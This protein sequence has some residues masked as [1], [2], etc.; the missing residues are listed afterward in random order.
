MSDVPFDTPIDRPAG[1]T[2]QLEST[3]SATP[4]GSCRSQETRDVALDVGPTS[5][6]LAGSEVHADRD[7]RTGGVVD[8]DAV[9]AVSTVDLQHVGRVGATDLG[10]GV[11][12]LGLDP[13][14]A[15]G[16][17]VNV[18][19]GVSAVEHDCVET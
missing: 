5:E 9:I 19:R 16:L 17:D 14:V 10:V 3:A 12:P 2:I 1:S 18:I 11:E 7:E 6:Q 4:R 13:G 8:V 15:F